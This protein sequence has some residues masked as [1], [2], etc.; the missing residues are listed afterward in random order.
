MCF[1]LDS[2][3]FKITAREMRRRSSNIDK[4]DRDRD[5][6]SMLRAF[7]DRAPTVDRSVHVR[8]RFLRDPARFTVARSNVGESSRGRIRPLSA[9]SEANDDARRWDPLNP[10][11]NDVGD[12]E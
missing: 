6:R 2:L 3:L 5:L 10:D 7:T 4:N 1:F 11:T 9:A 12:E 8:E